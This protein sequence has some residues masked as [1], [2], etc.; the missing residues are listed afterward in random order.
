MSSGDSEARIVGSNGVEWEPTVGSELERLLDAKFAN[1]PAAR[2]TVRESTLRI[3]RQ[4][5]NPS[6]SGIDASNTGLVVGYVQS[7][8]TLSFTSVAA[9]AHD[10]GFRCVVVIAGS[11]L[12]LA[13]QNKDRLARD[14]DIGANFRRPWHRAHNPTTGQVHELNTALAGWDNGRPKTLL[15]TSLKHYRHVQNL[16]AL[17]EAL[18]DAASPMLI[19]DDEADQISLNTRVNQNDESPNYSQILGLRDRAPRHTY[20]QYTATPQANIFIPLWDRLSPSFC[21]PLEPGDGYVGGHRVFVDRQDDL[22]RVISQN[23]LQLS[24]DLSQ[25]PPSLHKAMRVFFL[26]VAQALVDEQRTCELPDPLNRSMMVHPSRSQSSHQVFATWIRTAMGSWRRALED[27]HDRPQQL[28]AF[29]DA[30]ADLSATDAE[31]HLADF[32]DLAEKLPEA[33][34]H[35]QVREV[36]SRPGVDRTDWSTEWGQAYSWILIGGQNLD[37]GFTVEGLTVTYMPRNVGTGQAD[38]IQQRARFF[39][40]KRGYEDLCRIYLDPDAQRAFSVYV[41]HE[42]S[43]RSFLERN[44]YRLSEPTIP[45]EFELDA[46]LRPTRAAVLV[47]NP[48]RY[49]LRRGWLAQESALDRVQRCRENGSLINEFVD[50][51]GVL[52]EFTEAPW[53]AD[54]DRI[55]N[56]HR[57]AGVV[58]VPLRE[59]YEQLL[60]GVVLPD[61]E[62]HT[63]WQVA[64]SMIANALD[65]Y[66][67]LLANIIVMRPHSE[68]FRGVDDNE[69]I[70]QVFAGAHPGQPPYA[71][72]GDREVHLDDVTL[73]FHRFDLGRGSDS[74]AATEREMIEARVP[75]LALW[76]G[77]RVNRPMIRQ[78]QAAP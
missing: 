25:A 6:R 78:D 76:L 56:D 77:E 69:R 5:V 49:I 22:V 54:V 24:D 14:L 67:D 32:D 41:R 37:R 65:E 18:G 45:R 23:D 68:P 36:N 53:I 3:L 27:E 74:A 70:K 29:Q 35:T 63:Q 11:S 12:N 60:A 28:A 61:A 66:D 58:N 73:Q 64:L 20:L 26:G 21:E 44:R 57:H 17:I 2:R 9:A 19:I 46:Q 1:N 33:I 31:N 39:G 10:N 15:L 42:R 16:G 59:V 48:T 47:D 55:R 4:C 38:T 62:E 40:Y 75:V 13:D 71:Y 34:G 7:G 51:L 30:Y 50:S 43:M 52:L 8:K 72:T